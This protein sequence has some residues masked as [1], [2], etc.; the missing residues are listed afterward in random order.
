L[1]SGYGSYIHDRE[2]RLDYLPN[3]AVNANR[4]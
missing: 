4:G 3:V 1:V 2:R